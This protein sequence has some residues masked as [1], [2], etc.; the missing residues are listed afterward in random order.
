MS[1]HSQRWFFRL[2]LPLVAVSAAV[3]PLTTVTAASLHTASVTL[4]STSEAPKLVAQQSRLRRVR[5][6]PGAS[7]ATIK[8][9]VVSGTRD[10]YLLS[11]RKGQKMSIRIVSL[12]DNAVFDVVAPVDQAGQQRTLKQEAFSW[13]NTL[14]ET[15]DYQIVVGSTR[16]NASYR[17]QVTIR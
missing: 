11:A 13:T 16:G 10:R 15:G 1:I 4:Q 7:S 8:D 3:L 5:F 6:A 2:A 17:L 12:E 9:S 14:P